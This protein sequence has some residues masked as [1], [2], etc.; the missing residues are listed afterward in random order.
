MNKLLYTRYL[1][2]I[3]NQI[4]MIPMDSDVEAL[5]NS[6][7]I[8]NAYQAALGSGDAPSATFYEENINALPVA[9]INSDDV[10]NSDIEALLHALRVALLGADAEV[11]SDNT[12]I[13]HVFR[14][15][16][17]QSDIISEMDVECIAHVCSMLDI[18]N[19]D[20]ANESN[21][22]ARLTM[23][24]IVHK[25][26]FDEHS[27]STDANMNLLQIHYIN[28]SDGTTNSY[29]SSNLATYY[30]EAGLGNSISDSDGNA[31]ARLFSVLPIFVDEE[32]NSS[33]TAIYDFMP[34]S[35]P[36]D[37]KVEI[38]SYV[39]SKSYTPDMQ[40]LMGETNTL[41]RIS[42]QFNTPDLLASEGSGSI[43]G[44]AI[45][46]L[47]LWYL[48]IQNDT[49]LYIRQTNTATLINGVLEVI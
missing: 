36:A 43:E 40:W 48:P 14:I 10:A 46:K 32:S 27:T 4:I 22:K 33:A 11:R 37:S 24:Q 47:K 45:G 38:E 16:N 44:Y 20:V 35:S 25:D 12:C 31:L 21:Y 41:Y 1:A 3:G 23:W 39:V 29:S 8:M 49:N 26:V 9:T 7:M 2:I 18:G 5:S 42:G 34:T 15:D 19:R 30:I 28:D 17:M 6:E 13:G